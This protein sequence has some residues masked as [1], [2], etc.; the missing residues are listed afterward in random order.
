MAKK[1]PQSV[2]Q[3]IAWASA[4]IAFRVNDNEYVKHGEQG[5]DRRTN[6]EIIVDVIKNRDTMIFPQ[7]IEE[8][9]KIRSYIGQTATAAA[10]RGTMDSW[11]Q[12]MARVSQLETIEES[13]DLNIIASM[14][15]TY[16]RHLQ[17]EKVHARLSEC[18]VY[19]PKVGDKLEIEC[20]VLSSKWSQKWSTYYVT[21]VDSAN[22]AFFFAHRNQLKPGTKFTA[23]GTVKRISGDQVQLN[24]VRIV[25]DL[26]NQKDI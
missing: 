18:E 9:Q 25:E 11:G 6:A 24:R 7:D 10:L 4:A 14:P 16:A 12:A 22:H 1:L 5:K 19:A 21:V 26:D 17:R 13:I 2:D 20:E 3:S 23:K 15:P 8:G